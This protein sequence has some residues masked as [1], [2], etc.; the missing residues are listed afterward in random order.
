MLNSNY[1][2]IAYSTEKKYTDRKKKNWFRPDT[3]Y[4][5][6][7]FDDCSEHNQVYE[8]VR[9]ALHIYQMD[10]DNY[11]TDRW[12]PLGELIKPGD[13]VIIKPNLVMD[14]NQSNE[15]TE[16]LFTQP[17]V[18]APIIDYILIALKGEGG[19]IIGDAP[20]QEC[21]LEKLLEE[22]GYN[23]MMEWYRKVG[24]EI[25]IV[26]FRGLTTQID[27]KKRIGVRKQTISDNQD[28]TVIDLADMS[29]FAKYDKEHL[30]KMRITNYSPDRLKEH[31][32][33]G[34]HEYFVSNYILNADVVINMPKPK[35]HRKAGYTAAMKNMVGMNVRK[36]YL[37]HHTIGSVAEGGDEYKKKSLLRNID[38]KL[39][40]IKNTLEGKER[41]KAAKF[42]WYIA[43]G[44][45]VL[46]NKVH[47]DEA[48]GNWYGNKTISKTIVDLNKILFYADKNGHIHDKIQRKTLNIGD[49]IISGEKEGPV[50]PSPKQIG[51]II[52]ASNAYIFDMGVGIMMG[53]DATNFPFAEDCK[54]ANESLPLCNYQDDELI[55]VSNDEKLNNKDI[56]SVSNEL[57]WKFVPTKGWTKMFI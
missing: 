55:Y 44:L 56:K 41:Y 43:G 50:A 5:E 51:A 38:D 36:E 27:S 24:V 54:N 49:M 15:G 26:D 45:K 1:V 53:A 20:M 37:P 30:E 48:E 18:V 2:G 7:M 4:P 39:Y 28:G 32:C 19:I 13:N 14:Y 33:P 25:K 29:Q 11:G 42:V 31:H 23:E 3:Q 22:S 40:D 12:N 9:E 8:A 46:G 10:N 34:R 52:I 6:M 17:E 47:H 16:C 35:T 21:N 57:K